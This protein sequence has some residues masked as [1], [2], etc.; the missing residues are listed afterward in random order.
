MSKLSELANQF[1]TLQKRKD[2]CDE[3]DKKITS[4]ITLLEEE[5]IEAMADEGVQSLNLE[6]GANVHRRVDRF[7][8]PADGVSK[9]DLLKE[10]AA[11]PET[12]DLVVA[13][14]NAGSLRAR[15]KEIEASGKTLPEELQSKLKVFEKHRIGYRS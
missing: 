14:F 5:L 8:S 2:K 13:K 7:F 4:E 6:C 1:V 10:M 11:H 3:E 9:E 12:M 15:I